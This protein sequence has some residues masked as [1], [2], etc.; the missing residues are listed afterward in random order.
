MADRPTCDEAQLKAYFNRV[1]LPEDARKHTIHMLL[2]EE[3]LGYLRL[4]MKHQLVK[5]PFENLT[6]HYSWHRVIDV[7]PQHLFKKIVDH[8][9]RGGYCMEAN[10]LFHTVLLSLGFDV[11]MAGAR[12]YEPGKQRYGGFSHCVNIITIAGTK[13]MVDVGFGANGPTSPVRLEP[14]LENIHVKPAKMRLL[15]EAIPQNLNQDCKIWIYQHRIDENTDWIP[16]YCFVDFEFLLED[17]RAMNF[18]PWKS[19]TSFFNQQVV[20]TRFT[21]PNES[22]SSD[23]PVL[24]SE[25]TLSGA[26]IDG[27]L[28]VD[29]DRF[30]WRRNGK[31]VIDRRFKDD[32][33]RVECLKKYF[34]VTM[35]DEDWKAIHGTV[36]EVK[37]K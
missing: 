27:A 31:C 35:D 13:Y 5:V 17:I 29:D 14:E 7:K 36:G 24:A 10:T 16:M 26:E 8:P 34:G 1:S 30:K 22:D 3:K 25:K 12:V 28:I 23:G 32:G 19:P 6:L 33:E 2:E 21:T 20:V 18:S 37:K 15:R 9:G 11:F 4:L